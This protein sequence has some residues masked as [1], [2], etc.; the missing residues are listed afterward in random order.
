MPKI[1]PSGRS[2]W[3]IRDLLAWSTGHFQRHGIDS[4]RLTAELLLAHALGLRRLDLYLRHDQPVDPVERDRYKPLI[5]RRVK[6]E[7]V[8]YITGSRGFWNLDLAVTT[9]VLIPRP[10]TEHLVETALAAVDRLPAERPVRVLDVGTGSGAVILA[11]AAER[12]RLRC[13]ASDR[14]RAALAVARVNARRLDLAERVHLFGGDWF[15]PLAAPACRFDLILANPPYIRTADLAGLAP[16]IRLHEPLGALDGGPD[17]LCAIR[18]LVA[19][20]PA[21]LAPGGQLCLEV[22]HDQGA[23]VTALAGGA[24]ADVRSVT[25]LAG[26]QRVLRLT[27]AGV[28]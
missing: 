12:P 1:T 10:E 16:E 9:A 11:L 15:A 24:Y 23:R 21:F 2:L 17:G 27:V 25:D 8:A 22:G 26:R 3:T 20:A 18:A 6:R 14:S 13:W 4:P 28:F 5:R 19:G 7:P